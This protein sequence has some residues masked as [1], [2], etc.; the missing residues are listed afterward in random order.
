MF[1]ILKII[2]LTFYFINISDKYKPKSQKVY[3]GFIKAYIEIIIKIMNL[4]Q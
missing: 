2:V 3:N 4:V 1:L